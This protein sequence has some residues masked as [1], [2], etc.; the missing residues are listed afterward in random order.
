MADDLG[1]PA[2]WR[3]VEEFPGQLFTER[4]WLEGAILL[5]VAY[6]VE[7]T[8]FAMCL[9]LLIRQTKRSNYI[10]NIPLI[11]YI[12]SLFICGTIFMAAAANMARLS[13]VDNRNFPGGPAMFE[14]IMFSIPIDNMGNVAFVV[15]NW[16][17]DGLMVWRWLVI[18]RSCGVPMWLVMFVPCSALLTSFILGV[19]F[20]VQVSAPAGN[21]WASSSINF[22][23][24]Y[25][26]TSLALNIVSTIVIVTRLLWFRR[27]TSNMLGKAHGTQY[28]SIAAMVV[29]SAAVYS[30][31]SLC[32]L[33]PFIVN[34]PIQ[35]VFLGLLSPA[36]V[37][38]PLLIILRVA[39]GRAWS[40]NTG[41]AIISTG[42]STIRMGK[43]GTFNAASNSNISGTLKGSAGG[44]VTIS[45]DVYLEDGHVVREMKSTGSM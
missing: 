8:L 17:A 29:E 1:D 19:L 26:C 6:G 13:F 21:L 34:H 15:A 39:Q 7:L 31:S 30:V 37:I 28:T 25:F 14:T 9:N 5:G 42:P 45:H 22:V 38:A 2:S 16:L 23:L 40:S 20:L 41:T 36:Q 18:Y 10:L 35:N 4:T 24:P 32:F 12:C 3:P 33:V 11:G 27:R 44:G 43:L